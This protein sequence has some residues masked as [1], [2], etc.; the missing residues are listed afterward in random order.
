M[1]L[2]TLKKRRQAKNMTQIPKELKESYKEYKKLQ[3]FRKLQEKNERIM[4]M[5]EELLC[6]NMS[7]SVRAKAWIYINKMIELELM[8]E[9][10]CNK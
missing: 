2:Y 1:S 3:D 7:D 4:F 10:K 9:E 5:L 6:D 8:L